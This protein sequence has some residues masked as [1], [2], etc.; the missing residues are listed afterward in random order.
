MAEAYLDPASWC[1]E[2][3]MLKKVDPTL[4]SAWKADK[5]DSPVK[6]LRFLRDRHLGELVELYKKMAVHCF[7][8]DRDDPWREQ[9]ASNL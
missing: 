3:E 8:T 4:V 5:N 9:N 7:D 6:R 1:V 2:K